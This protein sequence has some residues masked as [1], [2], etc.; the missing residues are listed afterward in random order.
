MNT[1][2]V[3]SSSNK[4]AR[5]PDPDQKSAKQ[6]VVIGDWLA[7]VASPNRFSVLEN[8]D[9]TEMSVH[10]ETSNHINSSLPIPVIPKPPPIFV[11]GV[12]EMK[13]LMEQLEITAKDQYVLKV[14]N[15]NQVKIQPTT[16]ES[17]SAIIKILAERKTSFHT[18]QMKQDR[19]Y[20]VV[21]KNTHPKTDVEDIKAELLLKGHVVRNISNIRERITKRP[22]P[23]FF[24]DLEPKDNNKEIYNIE[25]LM[26]CRVRFEPPHQKREVPQCHNCQRYGHTKKFCFHSPR[27]VKC[28]QDH[29]TSECLIKENPRRHVCFMWW[30]TPCQL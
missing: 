11:D 9:D 8:E 27:C 28:T 15:S 25:I 18:F 7:S 20:R 22:M 30:R 17:Y 10:A 16:R 13:P 23:L 14:M 2:Q 24:V 6:K 21:L 4:R 1:E 29:A 3:H 5:S 26:H 19:S 12:G